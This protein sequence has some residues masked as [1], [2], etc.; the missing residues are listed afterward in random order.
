MSMKTL[1]F[2]APEEAIAALDEIAVNLGV[3][4]EAVLGLAVDRYLAQHE[5]LKAEVE[6]AERQIDAGNFFTQEQI[7]ARFAS[8]QSHPKAA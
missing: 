3:S 5:D 8:M 2:E 1:T 6:E 7:E 4:R